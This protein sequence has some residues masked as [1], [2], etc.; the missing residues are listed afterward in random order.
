MAQT[1]LYRKRHKRKQRLEA[2]AAAERGRAMSWERERQEPS[3]D[4]SSTGLAPGVPSAERLRDGIDTLDHLIGNGA[5]RVEEER[6][7]LAE[8]M[9]LYEQHVRQVEELMLLRRERAETE[10]RVRMFEKRFEREQRRSERIVASADGSR[11]GRAVRIDVDDDAWATIK[12]EAV[13]RRLWL[14]WWVGELVRVEVQGLAAGE[15]AGRP[16]SRRRRSPGE[17]D[18]QLRQ[19]FLRIDVGDD[20]WNTF[21]AAALDIDLTVGRYVGELAEIVAYECGWRA[22]A[23]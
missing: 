7:S 9:E 8:W 15:A 6:E 13:R 21:R 17:G 12:R 10:R 18:P 16:S 23:E 5:Q 19:R 11:R 20:C 1:G 4:P 3:A 22:S 2:R 14:V